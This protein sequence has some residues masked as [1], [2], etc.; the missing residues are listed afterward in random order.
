MF[1]SSLIAA[2]AGFRDSTPLRPGAGVARRV[3]RRVAG[4]RRALAGCVG[5]IPGNRRAQLT[6]QQLLPVPH[7][8]AA[9]LQIGPSHLHEPHPCVEHVG[10]RV[11]RVEI[12]LADDA[13]VPRFPRVLEQVAIETG[14]E[15]PQGP[16]RSRSWNC[17]RR[18]DRTS[19]EKSPIFVARAPRCRGSGPHGL[20]GAEGVVDTTS[21][22]LEGVRPA[23]ASRLVRSRKSVIFPG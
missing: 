3:R 14:G 2:C 19:P 17:S 11:R 5:A 8:P 13:V 16:R 20:K 18:A 22:R 9:R 21:K 12:D 6:L 1:C 10:A 23:T 7:G 15:A 4:G